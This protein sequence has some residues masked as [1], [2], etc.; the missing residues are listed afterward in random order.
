MCV[1]VCVCVCLFLFL[2]LSIYMYRER[3]RTKVKVF[4]TFHINETYTIE[5]IKDVVHLSILL[6]SHNLISESLSRLKLVNKMLLRYPQSIDWSF[7]SESSF[8]ALILDL[9]QNRIRR[10]SN[11]NCWSWPTSVIHDRTFRW[12]TLFVSENRSATQY[13]KL[14]TSLIT[15]SVL[16]CISRKLPIEIHVWFSFFV[17]W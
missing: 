9:R 10:S 17:E 3:Q 6:W 4:F 5:A 12:S 16:S 7:L 14:I 13:A 1:C 11:Y 8:S 15:Q 2:S